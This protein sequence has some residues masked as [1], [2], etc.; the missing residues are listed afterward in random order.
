MKIKITKEHYNTQKL[1]E[2]LDKLHSELQKF[3]ISFGDIEMN[4]DIRDKDG[5]GVLIT[6]DGLVLDYKTEYVEENGKRQ[7]EFV[8]WF[9]DFPEERED[10]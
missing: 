4:M 5:E 10:E 2:F 7:S 6:K 3:D 9:K 1:K 8:K